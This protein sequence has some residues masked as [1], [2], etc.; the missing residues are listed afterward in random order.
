MMIN[1]TFA[2]PVIYVLP[3]KIYLCM[4]VQRESQENWT[5]YRLTMLLVQKHLQVLKKSKFYV[6]YINF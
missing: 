3:R 2:D 1:N 5:D 6:Q 4:I